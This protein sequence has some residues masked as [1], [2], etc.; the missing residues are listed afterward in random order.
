MMGSQRYCLF[1]QYVNDGTNVAAALVEVGDRIMVRFS[2]NNEGS[3]SL[4]AMRSALE[5]LAAAGLP[6]PCVRS[7]PGK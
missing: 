5:P 2:V 3:P 4:E 7:P 1:P 6:P